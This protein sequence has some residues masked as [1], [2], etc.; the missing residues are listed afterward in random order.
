MAGRCK[1]KVEEMTDDDLFVSSDMKKEHERLKKEKKK[2]EEDDPQVVPSQTTTVLDE[3]N[4]CGSLERYHAHGYVRYRTQYNNDGQKEGTI[5]YWKEPREENI[6]CP[7]CDE[8]IATRTT[9]KDAP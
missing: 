4:D 7:K 5:V 6:L 2:K 9:G 1:G 3:C 8:T